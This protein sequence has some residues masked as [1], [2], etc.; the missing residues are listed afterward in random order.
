M[1]IEK[2]RTVTVQTDVFAYLTHEEIEIL[3]RASD[4]LRSLGAEEN[5]PPDNS[6]IYGS[7]LNEAADTIEEIVEEMRY[8]K[9]IHLYS[10]EDGES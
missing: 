1:T 3:N 10:A 6:Y 9:R 7:I 2:K 4:L 5:T 8:E